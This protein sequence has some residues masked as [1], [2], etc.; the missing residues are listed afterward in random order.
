MNVNNDLIQQ[1]NRLQEENLSLKKENEELKSLLVSNNIKYIKEKTH[2][3][4]TENSK[5]SSNSTKQEKISL[6]RNLFRGREDVFPLRWE[7]RTGKSGYS[8][9][10]DNQWIEGTCRKP[11]IK[12]SNCDNKKYTP[13]TDKIIEDHLSGKKTIGIYT[14]DKDDKCYFLACDFDKEN[15]KKD[16]VIYMKTAKEFDIPSYLERSRSGNGGHVWIFFNYSITAYKARQLGFLIIS[17]VLE[18]HHEIGLDSYDRLFPNQD[19]LP[20]GGFGNLIALPLQHEPRKNGNSIFVDETLIPYKDQWQFLSNIQKTTESEID[21]ILSLNKEK[22]SKVNTNSEVQNIK[23]IQSENYPDK[24]K[25]I[26]SNMIYIDKRMLPPQLINQLVKIASFNNPEFYKAQSMRL[27]TYGKPRFINCTENLT[28][29]LGL[30]RGCFEKIE[31]LLK[32]NKINLEI[33]DKRYDGAQIEVNFLG[34]LTSLQKESVE[35]LTKHDFEILSAATSFGKTVIAAYMI[36]LRKVNTLVLVHRTQ[37]MEQWIEQLENFLDLSQEKIGKIGNNKH[38]PSMIIDVATI[39]SLNREGKIDEIVSKYG[40]VI[41]DECHHISAF[42]FEKVMKKVKAKY[43]LGLTATP[44]RKDGHE[45]IIFMQ[46]GQIRF[47]VKNKDIVHFKNIEHSAIIKLVDT[48]ID[49]NEEISLSAIYNI[50][51]NYKERNDTILNDIYDSL[52]NKRFPL[53]LTERKEHLELL[54]KELKEKNIITIVL[55]GGMSKK[56]MTLEMEKFKNVEI[57]NTV[58]ISTGRFIGEGFDEPRLDTLFLTM[59]ISWKG[60]LQ[61]YV[62][63]LHRFHHNKKEVKV[64]D[65]LDKNIPVLTKMYQRRLKGYKNIGYSVKERTMFD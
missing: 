34:E 33:N 58:I 31:E 36:A 3:I 57:G 14:I 46:C 38:S 26:L 7:S 32:S 30:P 52:N 59:P 11:E 20:K 6:F 40:Q 47:I 35:N 19:T 54:D 10:C 2:N 29:H 27:S 24:I 39:Q 53:V 23:S 41:V 60:T 5:V 12:C 8:P 43:V 15:W 42:S 63:R 4:Q 9:S 50:L 16:A 55:R 64:Y 49:N 13:L 1:I 48:S 28:N 61:Q 25:I 18:Y 17:K 21:R 45:P 51:I 37:L 62:G 22:Y 65:Y 44:E 56:K